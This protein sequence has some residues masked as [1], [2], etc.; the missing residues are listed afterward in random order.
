MVSFSEQI[1]YNLPL[2]QLQPIS[3]P[4]IST[5][6]KTA[7][8]RYVQ[9]TS[10]WEVFIKAP[11]LRYA[12]TLRVHSDT[13]FVPLN[14]SLKHILFLA[15]NLP[16]TSCAAKDCLLGQISLHTVGTTINT[17]CFCPTK[18]A[19]NGKRP[20]CSLISCILVNYGEFTT[21]KTCFHTPLISA[22]WIWISRSKAKRFFQS[23]WTADLV[24][25]SH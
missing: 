11:A 18:F 25:F 5:I 24:S 8:F 16:G 17:E 10:S 22:P 15:L 19:A 13:K 6:I 3:T 12:A 23:F 2:V 7:F 1:Q 20:A 14:W 4:S 9:N 21:S